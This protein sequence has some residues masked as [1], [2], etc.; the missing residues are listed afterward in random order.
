MYRLDASQ[1][2][3]PTEFEKN[4]TPLYWK[5]ATNTA[6][7]RGEGDKVRKTTPED[8]TER[9]T[10]RNLHAFMFTNGHTTL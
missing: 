4:S 9:Q 1:A 8:P 2:T 7:E 6:P 3:S 5:R 10:L